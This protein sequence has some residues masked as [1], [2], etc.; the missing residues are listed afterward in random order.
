MLRAPARPADG[1][2]CTGVTRESRSAYPA[3]TSAA[4]E[5]GASHTGIS[6]KSPNDWVRIE[7]SAWD[8]RPATPWDGTTMLKRGILLF[9]SRVYRK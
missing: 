7:S 3:T 2:E 1:G 6:S 8:S 9:L 5:S 4:G